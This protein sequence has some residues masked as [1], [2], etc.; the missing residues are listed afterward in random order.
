[1][2]DYICHVHLYLQNAF[3]LAY[4]IC[5]F[6]VALF[7]ADKLL[8]GTYTNLMLPMQWAGH[9]LLSSDYRDRER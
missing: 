1:M 4:C 7:S 9:S 6:S 2:E 5:F 3:L 8:R